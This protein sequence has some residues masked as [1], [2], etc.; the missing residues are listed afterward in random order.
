MCSFSL[1][2]DCVSHTDMPL[3]NTSGL[4][5][6]CLDELRITATMFQQ[7][8]GTYVSQACHCN[9]FCLLH[10]DYLNL[11]MTP[12]ITVRWH[13]KLFLA[14][15]FTS[16][17]VAW[18]HPYLA[19]SIFWGKHRNGTTLG[20]GAFHIRPPSPDLTHATGCKHSGLRNH[21]SLHTYFRFSGLY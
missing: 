7:H 4:V 8:A 11:N 21:L 12:R 16:L 20:D 10:D 6:K 15:N 18:P 1:L 3:G 9:M 5:V 14:S 2:C 19:R 13:L 17:L